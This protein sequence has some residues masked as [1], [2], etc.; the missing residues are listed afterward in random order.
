MNRLRIGKASD[1]E[2]PTERR[3]YR[4]LEMFP[5]IMSWGT[6]IFFL[7]LSFL[8]PLFVAI[9]AIAFDLYWFFRAIYLVFHLR[10]G[11]K[12]MREH[13]KIDWLKK[14][15]QL[16]IKSW[17]DIYHLVILPN[18]KEP[19][20][21]I[22]E[23]LTAILRSDYPKERMLI[24]LGFEERGGRERKKV[25]KALEKE[26]KDKFFKFL[27][28]W[29]PANIA[30]EVAGKGANETW[31]GKQV[32][33][34]I[35]DPLKIPYENIIVS[36]FDTDT[37]V[38]PKYFSCLT[39]HYLTCKNPIRTSF[40]PIPLY[41]N[42]IWQAPAISQAFS[43]SATFWQIMCQERPEKL[44]TFSSHSMSLKALLDVDWWQTN[45]VSEDSRI[46]WQCL[47]KF[48]GDYQVQALYYPISM[49]ANVAPALFQ[50]LKNIYKQQRRWAYGVE[51]VFYFLF[52]FLKNK[53]IPLKKK[54]SL[55]F[56]SIEGQW[57]WATA[58]ILIFFLGW[59]PILLGGEQFSQTLISFNLPKITSRILTFSMIGIIA[60]IYYGI[61]LFPK[62]P[63]KK[64]SFK[65]L[66][67]VLGWF[68]VP[69]VMIFL[70][71]LPALEAQTRWMLGKYLG[72][73]P[74]PKTRKNF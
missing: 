74:T 49:D 51:N 9:F 67:F 58:S 27:I 55:G 40:Q 36:S 39:Y 23:S 57:S 56:E 35:I 48:N 13:E 46:F 60:S 50:T 54:L 1:L 20:E 21:I 7:V 28:T 69:F 6:L 52:G 41:T 24:V 11:F 47:L 70:T 16:T 5:G 17:K 34:K 10:S 53:K 61:S 18:Y 45:V 43:F 38:F 31:A 65:Y 62:S 71:S 66:T 26:F 68:L 42:N 33:E 44:I 12:R 2:D 3:I 30:G 29:H 32:K 15:Q 4:A 25:A 73:W 72:F 37:V 14:L 19:L 64:S 63:S 22:R 59:L 8:K